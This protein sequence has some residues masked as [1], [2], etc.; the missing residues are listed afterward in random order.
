MSPVTLV[1]EVS[2]L[3]EPSYAL[4]EPLQPCGWY[5]W[6]VRAR[7]KLNG[8]PRITEW[9]GAYK[10]LG[11]NIYPSYSRRNVTSI[12]N[13]WPANY[14]YYPFRTPDRDLGDSCWRN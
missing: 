1:H 6:T 5:F 3:K 12:T 9:A 14:L 4:A 10:T 13:V 8:F 11:G 2:G 7:F